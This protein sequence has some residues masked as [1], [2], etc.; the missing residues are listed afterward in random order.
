MK[1]KRIQLAQRVWTE[2]PKTMALEEVARISETT[3]ETLRQYCEMGLLGEEGRA[4]HFGEGALF[5][6][7]RIEQLRMEYGMPA[8]GA[9]LVLDLAARVEAVSYTHLRAHEAM[10]R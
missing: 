7:R 6:V 5:L 1:G 10:G 3:V 8:E 4:G 9:G 2:L